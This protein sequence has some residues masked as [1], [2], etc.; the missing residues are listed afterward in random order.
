MILDTFDLV[1]LNSE[2]TT[3]EGREAIPYFDSRHIL[4]GGVGRNLGRGFSD[5]EIDFMLLNDVTGACLDLDTHVPWWRTLP[6][7]QQRVMINLE[8]NLG[9]R[10]FGDFVKFDA[11][12]QR[13]DYQAAA[14]ELRD[15]LWFRQVGLRGP[16]VIGRLLG[17]ETV[18]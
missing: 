14:P 3:D 6:P 15:S 17:S 1:K 10:K 12:M 8:F 18:A 7:A 4:T 5:P 2:L 9:W 13:K 16:R 11:A